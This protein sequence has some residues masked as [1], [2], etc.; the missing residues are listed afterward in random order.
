MESGPM[1]LCLVCNHGFSWRI[2]PLERVCSR[3]G[4]LHALKSGIWR[5][6]SDS[7]LGYAAAPALRAIRQG[8]TRMYGMNATPSIGMANERQ[9]KC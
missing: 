8:A 1:M 9:A 7:N 5:L 4:T 6:P 3:C 2:S